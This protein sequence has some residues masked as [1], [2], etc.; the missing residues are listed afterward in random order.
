MAE[1]SLSISRC[2]YPVELQEAILDYLIPWDRGVLFTLSRVCRFWR[3]RSYR[4][5]FSAIPIAQST[6]MPFYDLALDPFSLAGIFPHIHDIHFRTIPLA[7]GWNAA[8]L[9]ILDKVLVLLSQH[10]TVTSVVLSGFSMDCH[11]REVPSFR[12][13]L[14]T[15]VTRL[16]ISGGRFRNPKELAQELSI[17]SQL[18]TVDFHAV[19]C[20]WEI[21]TKVKHPP[22]L[23]GLTVAV[24]AGSPYEKTISWKLQCPLTAVEEDELHAF[25][26]IVNADVHGTIR[27]LGTSLYDLQVQLER[28]PSQ[29]LSFSP[30]LRRI[31]IGSPTLVL[32]IMTWVPRIL[33]SLAK[34]DTPALKILEIIFASSRQFHLD[35][36]F[37]RCL[38]VVLSQPQYSGVLKIHFI[39]YYHIFDDEV[40]QTI[41]KVIQGG[42]E[43][44]NSRGLLEFSFRTH[45][46]DWA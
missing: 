14:F 29:N 10:T 30:C 16:T 11:R 5:L 34:T 41:V 8:Q 20:D 6:V 45:D 46:C 36:P 2:N 21:D 37:L 1:P 12:R 27:R 17:F 24:H 28:G 3:H 19:Y 9:V 31:S 22:G 25:G 23:Y 33:Y 15:A 26:S 13:S 18:Q 32:S 4:H 42:L 38:S 43:R 44:W 35:K 40:E 7:N 39:A